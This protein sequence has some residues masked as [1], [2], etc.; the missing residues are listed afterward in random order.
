MEV[1]C[2]YNTST[3]LGFDTGHDQRVAGKADWGCKG[4]FWYGAGVMQLQGSARASINPECPAGE[5]QIG[6][7]S[8]CQ[9][10][11]AG[12]ESPSKKAARERREAPNCDF[13]LRQYKCSY[14]AYLDA[15]PGMKKWAELNPE[16]AKKESFRLQSVD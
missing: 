4:S 11:P 10:P 2:V 6:Y 16:M 7:N 8:T 9:K 3:G 1:K 5:P 14:N 12:W 13:R 15:N